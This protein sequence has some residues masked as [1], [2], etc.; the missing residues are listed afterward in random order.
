MA[1]CAVE[2]TVPDNGIATEEDCKIYAAATE[3]CVAYRF[4]KV[5]TTKW[6]NAL[7]LRQFLY[8]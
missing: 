8:M 2:G 4:I 1:E 5:V 6:S 7:P 3:K